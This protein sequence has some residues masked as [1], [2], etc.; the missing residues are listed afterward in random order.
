MEMRMKNQ[1]LAGGV[2]AVRAEDRPKELTSLITRLVRAIMK[3][4]AHFRNEG[5]LVGN[6]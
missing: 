2:A 3:P 5:I 1:Q 4:M 6:Q